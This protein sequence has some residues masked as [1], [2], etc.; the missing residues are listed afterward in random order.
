[1]GGVDVYNN[2]KNTFSHI[3]L[4]E[5]TTHDARCF[6]EDQEH[7]MWIG[8]SSGIFIV[9]TQ[10]Q[11]NTHH[12]TTINS[13]LPENMIR[14]IVQDNKGQIWVGTF[15]QGLSI[16]TKNM[17]LIGHFNENNGFCSNC[18]NHIFKDSKNRIWIATGDGLACFAANE[19]RK[20]KV[21]N[22]QDGIH[23]AHIRA[24]T[25]DNEGNIWFSTNAGISC[26]TIYK[27]QLFR[28]SPDG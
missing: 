10:T 13:P 26:Y 1:M 15:G 8:T 14:S 21:Y 28:K 4:K 16:F 19:N 7:N 12:Y 27:L 23:N 20:Y 3:N 9:N 5:A 17:H 6:Y 22:R 2:E 18:I 24:I 25:E 11:E